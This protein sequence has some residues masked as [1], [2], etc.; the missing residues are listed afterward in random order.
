MWLSVSSVSIGVMATSVLVTV[1]LSLALAVRI[2]DRVLDSTNEQHDGGI[3]GCL[4]DGEDQLV[5]MTD[6]LLAETCLAV[7][8]SIEGFLGEVVDAFKELTSSLS[9]GDPAEIDSFALYSRYRNLI[10]ATYEAKRIVMLAAFTMNYVGMATAMFAPVHY[11][12]ERIDEV[13]DFK[14]AFRRPNTTILLEFQN[15]FN[16]H[17][18]TMAPDGDFYAMPCVPL[19]F[20]FGTASGSC[21][22]RP[23]GDR[24]FPLM[25]SFVEVDSKD[26]PLTYAVHSNVATFARWSPVYSQGGYAAIAMR[27]VWSI[28]DAP[29]SNQNPAGF[30]MVSHDLTSVKTVLD[31]IVNQEYIFVVIGDNGRPEELGLMVGTTH[32]NGTHIIPRPNIITGIMT[33]SVFPLHCLN[34]THDVPRAACEM[35]YQDQGSAG[36]PFTPAFERQNAFGTRRLDLHTGN[37]TVEYFLRVHP[38]TDHL[39]LRWWVVLLEEVDNILGIINRKRAA[40]AAAAEAANKDI[41]DQLEKDRIMAYVWIVAV[42][43]LV[44]I[45]TGLGTLAATRPLDQLMRDME[46]VAMMNLEILDGKR[47]KSMIK[48]L[49]S[50]QT[51]FHAVVKNMKEF[52]QFMPASLLRAGYDENADD[53]GPSD[54]SDAVDSTPKHLH[55][56]G[57]KASRSDATSDSRGPTGYLRR[58]DSGSGSVKTVE[59]RQQ[60]TGTDVSSKF[61]SMSNAGRRQAKQMAVSLARKHR[62]AH[63]CAGCRDFARLVRLTGDCP[64]IVA[65]HSAWLHACIADAQDWRGVVVGFKA[66][67]VEVSFGGL[68]ACISPATKAAKYA[69]KMRGRFAAMRNELLPTV[70]QG[71][72]SLPAVGIASGSVFV[73][74][75]GC[76]GLKAPAVLGRAAQHSTVMQ[77]IACEIGLDIVTDQNSVDELKGVIVCTP[78][79]VVRLETGKMQ[80][81]YY[82]S[83]AMSAA[84]GEWM[85]TM[86]AGVG[87]GE[88][89]DKAWDTLRSGDVSAAAEAFQNMKDSEAALAVGA[90][91]MRYVDD[92]SA[93]T[94]KA[95]NTYCRLHRKRSTVPGVIADSTMTMSMRQPRPRVLRETASSQSLS[96][97]TSS[98]PKSSKGAH[99]SGPPQQQGP[100]PPVG[101][102]C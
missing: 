51:S 40:A 84:A 8:T 57:T 13:A 37:A 92:V 56:T 38:L 101:A 77:A 81:A 4:A 74:N 7:S 79:D 94:G 60:D 16:R 85:Y 87:E 22:M 6:A 24:E 82:L 71:G 15:H 75:L 54:S 67:R 21:A 33:M 12:V 65:F 72:C 9:A 11:E 78:I 26:E 73:G 31:S 58:K 102:I 48:E 10:A 47:P 29:Y 18:G 53:D 86:D 3:A 93:V 14:T 80:I 5:E 49:H 52:R 30:V 96:S 36:D 27:G 43:V 46:Q 39:G 69:L 34:A 83:E 59:I 70:A 99:A 41:Q 76:Q 23:G 35:L 17:M 98:R 90:R 95:P 55:G 89:Y 91:L 61:G 2:T 1:I 50:M 19:F 66:D 64:A 45:A 97:R 88:S 68:S 62:S 42:V 28:P 32:G 63:V 20:V 25:Q 100:S 44:V